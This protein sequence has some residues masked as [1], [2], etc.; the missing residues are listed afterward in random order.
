MDSHGNLLGGVRVN[1]NNEQIFVEFTL[2][3]SFSTR[4]VAMVYKKALEEWLEDNLPHHLWPDVMYVRVETQTVHD[5][6][7]SLEDPT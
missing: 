2:S 7:K 1:D 5:L 6:R 4:E 3:E